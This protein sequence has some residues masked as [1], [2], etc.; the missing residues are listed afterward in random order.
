MAVFKLR[1]NKKL[2]KQDIQTL[3]DL[4]WNQLGTTSDYEKEFGDMPV[5]KL[6]RK[7]VGLDRVAA[8]EAFL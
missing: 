1:N 6:V 2:T 3:E 8:N 5:G 4:M 7:I